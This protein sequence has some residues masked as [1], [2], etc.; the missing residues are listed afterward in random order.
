[1]IVHVGSEPQTEFAGLFRARRAIDSRAQESKTIDASHD[2][3]SGAQ[4]K[5]LGWIRRGRAKDLF[6]S[7]AAQ[8]YVARTF[9]SVVL[10]ISTALSIRAIRTT[11]RRRGSAQELHQSR[12][13]ELCTLDS[14]YY[15]RL[16]FWFVTAWHFL[17]ECV[18][19]YT[20]G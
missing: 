16:C 7:A 2:A 5:S 14:N 20:N 13:D 17:S 15:Y 1:M 12:D 9:V 8:V 18:E 11:E 19:A 6:L 4:S 10:I 3:G